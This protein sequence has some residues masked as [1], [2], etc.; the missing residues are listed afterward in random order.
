MCR[1]TLLQVM[2]KVDR[3]DVVIAV[4]GGIVATYLVRLLDRT[5]PRALAVGGALAG[6]LL[7]VAAGLGPLRVAL[8]ATAVFVIAH[9]VILVVS[10][11]GA[12]FRWPLPNAYTPH[13]N[14]FQR[15]FVQMAITAIALFVLP[16][17]DL[18]RA[19]QRVR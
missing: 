7:A 9:L 11:A 18:A 1:A 19:M 14:L 15:V 2:W 13:P 17:E 12:V 8:V 4:V 6:S 10:F 16:A 5:T 3:R